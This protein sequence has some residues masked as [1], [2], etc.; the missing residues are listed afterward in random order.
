M[1]SRCGLVVRSCSANIEYLLTCPSPRGKAGGAQARPIS[2]WILQMLTQRGAALNAEQPS[3]L[4]FSVVVVSY[5]IVGEVC[6][7]CGT[8]FQRAVSFVR[9]VN[10]TTINIL[11]MFGLCPKVIPSKDLRLLTIS[12]L[13]GAQFPSITLGWLWSVGEALHL[14]EKIISVL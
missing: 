7:F 11:N 2:I 1:Q 10:F 13:Q 6:S 5:L 12:F 8:G 14:L 4:D 9:L 3:Q